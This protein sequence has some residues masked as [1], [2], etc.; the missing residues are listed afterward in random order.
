MGL[1]YAFGEV[2]LRLTAPGY[3]R[4]MQT[5]ELSATFVCLI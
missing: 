1:K 4:L 3:E 2:M 5:P